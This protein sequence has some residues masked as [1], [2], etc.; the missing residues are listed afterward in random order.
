VAANV[1]EAWVQARWPPPS[2]KINCICMW[3]Q[4]HTAAAWGSKKPLGGH[5]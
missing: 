5:V 3:N 2:K 4:K 1:N